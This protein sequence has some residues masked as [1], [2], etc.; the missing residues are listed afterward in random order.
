MDN[1]L[2]W[3]GEREDKLI[4]TTMQKGISIINMLFKIGPDLILG[5]CDK[6]SSLTFVG[7]DGQA[8]PPCQRL[9]LTALLFIQCL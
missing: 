5:L 7:F 1:E 8:K 4:V 2:G 6:K 3:A 9:N